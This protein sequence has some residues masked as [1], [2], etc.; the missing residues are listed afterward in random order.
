MATLLVSPTVANVP[1]G[2]ARRTTGDSTLKSWDAVWP[3][4]GLVGYVLLWNGI[5]GRVLYVRCQWIIQV[6]IAL[7]KYCMQLKDK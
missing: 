3:Y 5:N 4:D 7:S 1:D 2:S 6:A